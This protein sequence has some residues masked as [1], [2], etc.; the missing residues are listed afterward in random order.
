MNGE[1]PPPLHAGPN[2]YEG[3]PFRGPPMHVKQDDPQYMQPKTAYDAHV[4]VFDMT[5]EPDR[6]EYE[7]IIQSCASGK[8]TVGLEEVQY[9]EDIKGWRILLRWYDMYLEPPGEVASAKR[10]WGGTDGRDRA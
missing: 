2:P 7:K 1:I 9:C 4:R 10:N 3:L 6:L 5:R 8:T